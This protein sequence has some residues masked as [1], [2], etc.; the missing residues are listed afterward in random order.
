MRTVD[1]SVI[2]AGTAALMGLQA[3]DL[4]SE[5]FALLRQFHDRRLQVAW[6]I[7]DWPDLMRL[8]QR[9]FRQFY[10]SATAYVAGDER[11]YLPT[12]K[13]YQALQSSTGQTPAN[14]DGTPHYPYWAEC[15][16]GYSGD[17]YAVGTAYTVGTIVRNPVNA[18]YYICIEDHTA[19]ATL[20]TS[21]FARLTEFNR[22]IDYAQTGQTAIAEVFRMMD[23]SPNLTTRVSEVPFTISAT[24]YQV[25]QAIASVWIEYRIRRSALIG[26]TFDEEAVY[27][28]GQQALYTDET[29]GI[30]NFYNCLETTTAG[31]SPE[32]A[33]DKWQL[34][35]IPYIFQQYLIQGAYADWL[36]ADGQEEKSGA[37]ESMAASF[38]ELEADKLHRQQK[39]TRRLN[40]RS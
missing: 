27:A 40:F 19:G 2:V 4:Q 35:E 1:Y 14:A 31:E 3:G 17:L 25:H 22:V 28:S 18:Y 10:S 32:S 34:V 5:D 39:Q 11:F 21:F 12:G 36:K 33:P 23:R 38:L 24:G 26:A 6:E 37:N 30:Y 29:T 9:Y 13:Y 8:E 20:D 7:H 15:A 16:T